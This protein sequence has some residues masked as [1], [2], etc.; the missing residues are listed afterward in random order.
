MAQIINISIKV[1]ESQTFTRSCPTVTASDTPVFT[2]TLPE[3]IT[4]RRFNIKIKCLE[5]NKSGLYISG[6]KI[7]E[8]TSFQYPPGNPF[9]D[10]FLGL[11]SVEIAISENAS[12]GAPFEY[13]SSDENY[14]VFD[15]RAERLFN[16]S[17]VYCQWDNSL[18]INYGQNLYYHLMVSEDPLFQNQSLLVF[19]GTIPEDN[20]HSFTRKLINIQID[21][22]YFWKV[23]PFDS[24]DYG[25]WTPTN[26]FMNL[27]NIPPDVTINRIYVTNNEYGDVEVYFTISDLNND[28]LY[29]TAF[30]TGGNA[31][32]IK[33][34]MSLLNGIVKLYNGEHKIIWRSGRDEQLV[35]ANDYIIYLTGYD[36]IGPGNEAYYGP[37]SMDNSNIGGDPGGI[38][39]ID[40]G[41]AL[42]GYM[43]KLLEFTYPKEYLSVRGV[44]KN[45]KFDYK[46]A[47]I[48]LTSSF[49]TWKNYIVSPIDYRKFGWKNYSGQDFI[50]NLYYSSGIKLDY[51]YTNYGIADLSVSDPDS[52]DS[53][54]IQTL[55]YV[56]QNGYYPKITQFGFSK[57]GMRYGYI[58]F[59][60]GFLA[61]REFCSYCGGKGWR[62]E[63]LIYLGNNKYQ[64]QPCSYCNGSRFSNIKKSLYAYVVSDYKPLEDWI[65][66]IKYDYYAV[67]SLLS[68]NIILGS[69]FVYGVPAKTDNKWPT[70]F[71][72]PTKYLQKDCVLID[73][74][75]YSTH[76]VY[77]SLYGDNYFGKKNY[78][79]LPPDNHQFFIRS[80]IYPA[81]TVVEYDVSSVQGWLKYFHYN[82]IPGY[83]P[84]E[85]P[86]FCNREEPTHKWERGI[87]SIKGSLTSIQ[88]LEPLKI[89]YLQ[90]GWDI[91]NTIHWQSTMSTT[92]R[93]HLQYC[94]YFSDGSHTD[95]IDAITEYSE[96]YSKANAYLIGPN[97]W[98]TYWDAVRVQLLEEGFDYR[99]RIRQFDVQTNTASQ[100]IYSG[101]FEINRH[102]SNPANIYKTEY[103][104]WSKQLFIYFRLDDSQDDLYDI[105]NVWYSEDGYTFHQVDRSDLYGNL[106]ALESKEGKNE[107]V[108][109]W[110]TSKYQLQPGDKYRV[111]IEVIPTKFMA[112]IDPPYLT[113]SKDFNPILQQAEN[114]IMDLSGHTQRYIYNP[115]TEELE[116]LDNPIPIPGRIDRI[117]NDIEDFKHEPAPSGVYQYIDPSGN[118]IDPSGYNN[119]LNEEVVPGISRGDILI[120]KEEHLDNLIN[121]ELPQ[122]Q[123]ERDEAVR[124]IRKYLI[125][126]GF[127]CNGFNNNDPAQGEFRFRVENMEVGENILDSNDNYVIHYNSRYEVYYR[128]QI[129]FYST[130]DSQD[131]RPLRDFLYD[132]DGNRI[133]GDNEQ[134]SLYR[135]PNGD[136]VPS[137]DVAKDYLWYKFDEDGTHDWENESNVEDE[138]HDF[139][140]DIPPQ[141]TT[142]FYNKFLIPKE[143][144][145]GSWEHK[146][147]N[148]SYNDVTDKLPNGINSFN[149]NYFIRVASYNIVSG[150][151]R[152]TPRPVIDKVTI[153]TVNKK[154]IIDYT[155]YGSEYLQ[156]AEMENVSGYTYKKIYYS[157]NIISE[158]W[159]EFNIDIVTERPS[160]YEMRSEDN[161]TLFVPEFGDRNR[162]CVLFH[163]YQY[164]IWY[165]TQNI[166][167]EN[168][169]VHARSKNGVDI[170]EYDMAIPDLP[171][172]LLNSY[173]SGI[174]SIA[175]PYVLYYD[176]KFY[177]WATV[178]DGVVNKIAYSVS[179]DSN[180]W[181][182]LSFTNI[183]GY[184]CCV[185]RKDGYYYMFYCQLESGISSIFLAKSTDG[186]NFSLVQN[187]AIIKLD[188]D[189]NS[190]SVIND[191]GKYYIYFTKYIGSLTRIYVMES[192]DMI[193][194]SNLSQVLNDNVLNPY[195]FFDYQ[196]GNI[197]K[198]MYY[199]YYD[200]VNYKLKTAFSNNREWVSF[201]AK[202]NVS[203]EY[204]VVESSMFGWKHQCTID[205]NHNDTPSELRNL[206][207]NEDLMFKFHFNDVASA[208]DY[209]VQS[210]W[211]NEF[212]ME[213][214]NAE[215]I[216]K[217]FR[218]NSEIKFFDFWS[219]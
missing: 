45:V 36:D 1:G 103:E 24:F 129:D 213:Q 204:Q 203:G 4:Q 59:R 205:M 66:P 61:D 179:H 84:G 182:E 173:K 21:H 100:W 198:K 107:H 115:E 186:I 43:A 35:S 91:Y 135:L 202:N 212:N 49:D 41:F 62:K 111:R 106:M 169:I 87:I 192:D 142:R 2:W 10:E 123:F 104:K 15:R 172:Q 54:L 50:K 124:N 9:T 206:S 210:A 118:I 89:I 33:T 112:G 70:G 68:S 31:G 175:A 34:K 86:G 76:G 71:Q 219:E 128:L 72:H 114:K 168:V 55:D 152:E 126:Q 99:L 166:Y 32:S 7:S 121:I 97:L 157:L 201:A 109:I 209:L 57:K 138:L 16:Q 151:S 190:P 20:S 116:K 144:L 174:Q 195:V 200:G 94:K 83:S 183:I 42:R 63:E 108:L 188:T 194:W 199:N 180:T 113:W 13:T 214:Y 149:Y 155:M 6:E 196:D 56:N 44:L 163:N 80:R 8:Q 191:N 64:R 23:R 73:N 53:E 81:A 110:D 40:V 28:T 48:P 77:C 60:K 136:V 185:I 105:T 156:E 39:S 148:N 189:I 120:E 11:C 167:G 158:T 95:Y 27:S 65:Y 19:N 197:I 29:I 150:I 58:R 46:L 177:M 96:F 119:W 51:N 218:Y 171:N 132:K 85:N 74:R 5:S 47:G 160:G 38:G 208:R 134:R 176:N 165:S 131:G 143:D 217:R 125:N 153:D 140:T 181:S 147:L 75:K 88:Q 18:D 98:H 69:I 193:H 207:G 154:I 141:E 184:N 78:Q 187:N 79:N 101:K 26:G 67:S 137:V 159:N 3:G 102:A 52:G 133:Q 170:A 164:Y 211:I 161:P 139:T 37:F 30:Y 216:P 130:F 25:D 14:F 215:I 93:I 22:T 12:S 127:Y 17:Q 146:Y 92:T 90:A 82:Y 117:V 178:F 145:P 162:P 122:Y